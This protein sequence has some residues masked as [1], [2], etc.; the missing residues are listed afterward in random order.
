MLANYMTRV[1]HDLWEAGD[2]TGL[3]E[4]ITKNASEAIINRLNG[5]KKIN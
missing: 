3:I 2:T 5:I 4:I 1:F